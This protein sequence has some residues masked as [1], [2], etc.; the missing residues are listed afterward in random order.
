VSP[1][2]LPAEIR[3]P[4][5]V[6]GIARRLMDA[7]FDTWC[8]GGALRDRLLG[9][10]ADDVDLATAATPDEVQALFPRTVAVG[11]KYGTVGVLDRHRVLHEVTTFR[12]D[13]ST[14]GRHA[15]VAYGVSIE[16]DLARRDFTINALAYHP[17]RHDWRDP[18]SGAADLLER[19]IV[20]A[21]GDAAVRFA[22]DHL[23][24]LRMVRFAASL[25]FDIDPATWTAAVA[26]APLLQGL[27][28]ER[29]R[30]EWFKG[31]TTAASLE[32]LV[33]LW[34]RVGATA[35]WMPELAEGF[36]L[37]APSPTRRDPVVLT[38]ALCR[39]PAAVLTRL[40]ASNSEIARGQAMAAGAQ[41]PASTEPTA[42]R[43]WLAAVGDAADDIT[44]LAEYR[45]G[46]LPDWAG[47]V[48]KIRERREATSRAELAVTGDDL[49]AD[50]FAAGPE[51]GKLLGRL[52]DAVL[53]NP[54]LNSRD[55]LLELARSWR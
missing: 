17:L 40:R 34:R 9:R 35:V 3:L 6:V 39:D 19:R 20:R 29:V 47:V 52:L 54:T 53:E 14:D 24:I 46:A 11:V 51:L 49:L 41:E 8:V 13:V 32:R 55:T 31:L 30:D 15:V 45:Q 26:A 22:E 7:G 1:T 21:V 18:F 5:E 38:A 37:V 36:P 50:G 44:A 42:V 4:D 28:A 25:G 10:S 16:E 33:D 12:K 27:S 23:R 48:A 43:R 2:P